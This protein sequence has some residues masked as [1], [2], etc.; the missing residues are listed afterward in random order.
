MTG[1]SSDTTA[2][3]R[4]RA[5][6]P[7]V[8]RLS[9]KALTAFGL[10]ASLAIGGALIYA[11]QPRDRNQDGEELFSTEN[12]ATADGLADLPRDYSGPILGPPL[13]GDL[14]KPILEVQNRGEPILSPAI[15]PPAADPDEQ[16]RL[17]E[18]EAARVS[19]LFF[20]TSQTAGAAQVAGQPGMA[21]TGTDGM[22]ASPIAQNP[23]QAFLNAAPD[24]QPVSAERVTAPASPYLLQA[25]AVIPAALI[26]GIRSD[27][28]GQIVAQVTENVY[29]SPSGRY[30]LIPQGTRVVGEYS[31]AVSFGQRRVL[32]VWNRLIF[33]DGRSLVLE[34]L[35]GA[36]A[37][38]FAGLEDGVDYHWA[39]MAKAAGLSTILAIGT[40]IGSEDDDPLVRAIR[41]GAGDTIADAGQQI[42][43]RQ[44]QVAPTLTIRQGFPIRI[45]VTKDL[46]LAP[47]GG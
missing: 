12:R 45:L 31:D 21:G 18:E 15:T 41:K 17:A 42:V 19:Q 33:P 29:D 30:L 47:Q 27:L 4:L 46:V 24:R 40:E 3:M 26:T 1:K 13:P 11:L 36:D 37:Q 16:R 10:I 9:R 23:R 43:E 35:P 25:G 14:G 22:V 2:P 28:P 38:G 7:K 8:T 20:E 32:L 5:E 39:E 34:R 6:P 44:L